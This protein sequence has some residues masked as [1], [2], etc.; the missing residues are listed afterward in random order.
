MKKIKR[1]IILR[2]ISFDTMVK[3]IEFRNKYRW[4][5]RRGRGELHWF[6]WLYQEIKKYVKYA[7]YLSGAS[8]GLKLF[9]FLPPELMEHFMEWWPWLTEKILW[10]SNNLTKKL[11]I[12]ILIAYFLQDTFVKIIYYLTGGEFEDSEFARM[13]NLSRNKRFN[14]FTMEEIVGPLKRIEKKLG[15]KK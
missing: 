7:F 13:E 15:T 2:I 6:R 8:L 11:I 1:R 10:L 5:K 9:P 4:R 3:F 12:Y 14:W